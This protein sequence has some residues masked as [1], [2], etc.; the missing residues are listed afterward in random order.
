MYGLIGKIE[1]V[2][3]QRE[4]LAGILLDGIACMPGCRSYIVAEDP[5][6]PDALWVTE[7]WASQESHRASLTLPSVQE[8]I[9]RGK[10]L[11]RGFA[12]RFETRPVGGQGL[13]EDGKREE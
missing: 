9:T 8:A 7:V 6:D 11:I 4:E 5:A 13:A 1:V 3:G 10:P 2:P 12:E